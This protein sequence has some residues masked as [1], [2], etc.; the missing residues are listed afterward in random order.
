MSV[1]TL[2]LPFAGNLNGQK[3]GGVFT[4]AVSTGPLRYVPGPWKGSSGVFIEEGT[5]NVVVNPSAVLDAS[6]WPKSG[7][8]G[9]SVITRDATKGVST[10]TSFVFTVTSGNGENYECTAQP[11][12]DGQTWTVSGWLWVDGPANARIALIGRDATTNGTTTTV[13]GSW[14][15]P[16][17]GWQFVSVTGTLGSNIGKV[18]LRVYLDNPGSVHFTDMQLEQKSYSTSLAR[19]DMGAGYTWAGTA[20]ASAS[21]RSTS[22]VFISPSTPR[23]YFTPEQGS[24]ACWL[25][26]RD[27]GVSSTGARLLRF[28]SAIQGT[29]AIILTR[30]TA[31]QV[32]AS[33]FNGSTIS[34]TA[35]NMPTPLVD[36]WY[37]HGIG[38]SGSSLV[39]WYGQQNGVMTKA[40]FAT[41]SYI[42]D[43][44][45]NGA[46]HFGG[47]STSQPGNAEVGD[48]ITFDH[49]LTDAEWTALFQSSR[50]WFYGSLIPIPTGIARVPSPKV[51][52]A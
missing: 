47:Y 26:L 44:N 46:F 31:G 4:S 32:Q 23:D 9:G 20:H 5:T 36:T 8:S 39:Y 10:L 40:V 7:G 14:I 30:T 17:T 34:S 1:P 21:T 33:W 15:G 11:A 22:N 6:G 35:P 38:W 37:F 13:V 51:V 18:G 2:L 25:R 48:V 41:R 12:S 29:Q 19:G 43:Q 50:P 42:A 45:F 28:G 16:T 24:I 27:A 49:L 3:A 52:P